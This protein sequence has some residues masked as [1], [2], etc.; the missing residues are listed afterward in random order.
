MR[1]T[2][3]VVE[4]RNGCNS[5]NHFFSVLQNIALVCAC[6]GLAHLIGS[7]DVVLSV[8]LHG[9]VSPES[10]FQQCPVLFLADECFPNL[11]PE[12]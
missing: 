8:V 1:V 2:A 10:E 4:G 9:N 5:L 12:R 11:L 3:V 7:T 6:T